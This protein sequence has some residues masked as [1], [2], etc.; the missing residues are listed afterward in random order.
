MQRRAEVAGGEGGELGEGALEEEPHDGLAVVSL[1][2]MEGLWVGLLLGV[3]DWGCCVHRVVMSLIVSC[4]EMGF[5][6]IVSCG[7]D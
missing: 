6:Y 5:I 7:I 4:M 3:G 2:V 1:G